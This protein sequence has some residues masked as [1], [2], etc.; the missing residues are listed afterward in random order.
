LDEAE[1][2][3]CDRRGDDRLVL[4]YRLDG[5]TAYLAGTFFISIPNA[6]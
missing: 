5:D 6:D 3:A 4:A 2:F 1:L